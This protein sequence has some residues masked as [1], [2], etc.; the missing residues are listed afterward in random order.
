MS[1]IK[2]TADGH[3]IDMTNSTPSLVTGRDAIAQ[4][5]KI[6][7]R[8]FLGEWFLDTQQGIPFFDRI[9]LRNYNEADVLQ[10]FRSE[11]LKVDG[12]TGI[13]DLEITINA[14]TRTMTVTGR[15]TSID[16]EIDFTQEI[17]KWR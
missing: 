17:R 8:F 14:E 10:I 15:A 5:L 13:Q 2:L 3:D 9:L 6:A 11:I 7:L 12:I 1:D 16:G 4:H